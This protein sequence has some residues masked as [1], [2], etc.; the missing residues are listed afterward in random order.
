MKLSSLADSHDVE[1][2]FYAA[3][4]DLDMAAM[5]TLWHDSPEATCVHP[6]GDLIQGT[7]AIMQGWQEIFRGSMRPQLTHTLISADIGQELAV[8]VV[9]EQIISSEK[10]RASVVA[11]NV[12][13]RTDNGWRMRMHHA[14]LPL[15]ERPGPPPPPLH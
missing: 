13:I 7:A 2:A 14:S 3:F 1:S 5:R 9:R 12:Y 8:H 15:V 10:R 4:R 6:G 11:T